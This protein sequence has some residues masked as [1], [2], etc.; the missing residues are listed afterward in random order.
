MSLQ[1]P[2]GTRDFYP[3]QMR[4]QNHIFS[5]CKNTCLA[6]GY[7]EYES[8]AFEQLELYTRKSGEEIVSQLYHFKDKGGRNMALRPEITPTLARMVNQKGTGLKLPIRWFSIPRLFRYERSQR[9]RLREFFQLNMD[10]IGCDSTWA[11]TDLISAVIEMLKSFGVNQEDFYVGI[12][13]RRLLA[14][15]RPLS[16]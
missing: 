16:H 12:S 3:D 9:G 4:I 2:K 6:F 5:V 1:A 14:G 11:E 15:F 7:E 13:S 10:I 8:P